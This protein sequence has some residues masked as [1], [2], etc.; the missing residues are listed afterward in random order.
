MSIPPAKQQR[1]ILPVMPAV[2]LLIAHA[3]RGSGLKS[4]PASP[5]PNVLDRFARDAHW[6]MLTIGSVAFAAA[7][8]WPNRFHVPLHDSLHPMAA[9]STGAV[10]LG[11]ALSGWRWH[12]RRCVH[13]A[14]A[15]TALWMLIAMTAW[16]H[17]YSA[18]PVAVHEFRLEAERLAHDV[19]DKPVRHLRPNGW[20]SEKYKLNMEFRLYFGRLIEPT[21][22]DALTSATIP[23][24]QEYFILAAESD[25]IES[26]LRSNGYLPMDRYRTDKDETL[27]LWG[28]R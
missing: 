11:V 22:I 6:G 27:R 17:V 19:G 4:D 26:V 28:R 15:A 18:E 7:S 16:W 8:G 20:E 3:W 14:A 2:A 24:D 12:R 21:S 25:E 9:V 1:Y 10:L 23:V 13:K 5:S